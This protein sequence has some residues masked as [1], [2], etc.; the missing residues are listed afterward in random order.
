M[1]VEEVAG[2]SQG[3]EELTLKDELSRAFDEVGKAEET[4]QENTDKTRDE[5]GRFAKKEEVAPKEVTAPPA[6]QDKPKTAPQSWRGEAK[7]K[8]D[9]IPPDIQAEIHRREEETHK[10]IARQD[11][12]RMFGKTLKEVI[13][14]YMPIINAEGGNPAAAIQSL[15]NT[16]YLLRTSDPQ[17]KGKLLQQIAQQYGA[18]LSQV[19]T[20]T[21]EFIDPDV[22]ALREQV[23]QLQ[24]K[25]SQF[26]GMTRHQQD[27]VIQSEIQA[28]SSD[29]KNVHFDTVADDMA[30]L[31]QAAKAQG[32]RLSLQDAYDR[33][34]WSKPEIRS[35]LIEQQFKDT[36]AKR[37][38]DAK[39][40]T[41]AAKRAGVSLKGS[42][43]V[44]VPAVQAPSDDLRQEIARSLDAVGWQ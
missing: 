11:E 16:A 38:S 21:E 15:L 36:E 37:I 13:T 27:Q 1:E 18:D 26:E 12:D 42:P 3:G 41:E 29:P 39:A 5:A 32:Q 34:V 10:A 44:A 43:G 6:T 17:T 22:K 25:L 8:W 33:A 14:P 40:K 4:S 30:I 35:T 9:A 28:F 23:T 31:I 19:S 20:Q 7:A 2:E 24:G